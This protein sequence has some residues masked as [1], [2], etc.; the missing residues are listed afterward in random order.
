MIAFP[1]SAD[2]AAEGREKLRIACMGDSLTQGATSSDRATCS[3]PAQLQLMLGDGYDVMNF[4]VGGGTLVR[5]GRL[6]IWG[7]L[8]RIQ[9][10]NINPDIVV[11]SLGTNDSGYWQHKD[12]FPGDYRDLIDALRALPSRPRIWI[13]APAPM[14]IETPGLSESRRENLL[15]RRPRLQELI[16]VI[17]D[18]AREKEVGFI[19]LN[20]PLADKPE[21]F[22][23]GDGIHMKDVGYRAMAELVYEELRTAIAE[24]R[25]VPA[26]AESGDGG[27]QTPASGLP[28]PT[29]AQ[30]QW[31]DCEIGLL[32]CFDLPIAAEIYTPNNTHRQRVDP[33]AYH[34]SKMDTDQ[35][36]T[37][38]KAASAK[39]ALF[40]GT[41]FSGFMQWQSDA[42]PYSLKQSKW[43]GGKGDV[44]GDFV[45][46]CR[47]ADVLPGIFFST[48]RN[49]HQEL[50]GHY[51]NW[52]KGKGTPQQEAYNR[53]AEK[54][55]TEL[56]TGYGDIFHVW[57]D[58]GNKTPAE[59]GGNLLPIFEKYQ[60]DGIFYH[61]SARSDVRWV[62]N[63][64]GHAGVPC[65]ATM[66]GLDTG[67]LSH[68]SQTWKR[69]LGRGD[70]DGSC[71]SPA[72]VDIPLRGYRGH[73]W[74][75]KPGQD[76]IVYPPDVLMQKYYT[77]V[78]RNANLIIGVVIKP[79]GTIPQADA[80][81]LIE[82]GKELRERFRNPVA[83]ANDV[84]GEVVTLTL[85]KPR[86]IDHV[87][88]QEQIAHG[89]RVRDHV[90]EGMVGEE[91]IKLA[92]GTV[93]GHKWIYRFEPRT[94]SRLRLRITKSLA[95]PKIRSFSCFMVG[96]E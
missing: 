51:V 68:N 40:T 35:W 17:K 29:P 66:P 88:L 28:R 72:I 46:S 75:Y 69:Y 87:V 20:T 96:E 1:V 55:F 39:Y 71:W 7:T 5:K 16:V 42:Y 86:E 26:N 48:H 41:H 62:G 53:I 10:G 50:W 70:P 80:K 78:G 22:T 38:A 73:N 63:E 44:V 12:E 56:M 57:F 30:L 85:P 60:P 89:E 79:D 31:Q 81:A 95:P 15:Q 19:D 59:G 76:H 13:C 11:I 67:D 36:L 83:V 8:K 27:E 9:T 61:S 52:G 33:A 92:E 54:Q 18:I 2:E 23:E 45:A 49:A 34:P 43:R 14:V 74:F 3:Y 24:E 91:W 82:F 6:N 37:V 90:V 84:E 47:K 65:H 64:S 58:A 21:L 4:G 93:I 77:S 25:E 32:F 94:V